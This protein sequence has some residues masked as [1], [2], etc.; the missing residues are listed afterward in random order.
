MKD[1]IRVT[2]HEEFELS[3]I[4]SGYDGGCGRLHGHTYRV[5]VTL[6]GPQTDPFG[7]VMDFKDLKRAMKAVIPDH[8]FVYFDED[9]IGKDIATTLYRHGIASKAYPFVTT[10][11]NMAPYFGKELEKTIQE[12]M[13]YK[14][15]EVVEVNLWETTNSHATYIKKRC[16]CGEGK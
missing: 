15:V 3:H 11:E 10:A 8:Y 5:E 16:K 7:M 6:E 14:D 9:E 4:L 2:R 13:G 1:I 12:E